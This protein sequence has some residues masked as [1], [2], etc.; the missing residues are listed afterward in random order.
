MI[1]KN[2]ELFFKENMTA[3]IRFGT[4][5]E[6]YKVTCRGWIINYSSYKKKMANYQMENLTATLKDLEDKHKKI[7][8]Q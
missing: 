8:K 7:T 3:E 6:A 4:I 2:T 5:W 1:T